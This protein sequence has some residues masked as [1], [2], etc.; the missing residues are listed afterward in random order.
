VLII[1]DSLGVGEANDSAEYGDSGS[2]TLSHVTDDGQLEL[3]ALERFGLYKLLGKEGASQASWSKLSP[4]SQGKSSVEGHWEMMGIVTDNFM[5]TYPDGFPEELL[6]ELSSRIGREIL[7]GKPASGTEII[8]ELGEEHM[9]TGFPIIYTS[10]DSVMQ[11]A[12]H[13]DI[14]PPG[15]LYEICFIARHLMTGKNGVARIIARPFIGKPGYFVRTIR[16]K[17][18]AKQIPTPNNLLEVMNSGQRITCIGRTADFFSNYC[19]ICNKPVNLEE[20][21]NE[22]MMYRKLKGGFLFVNLGDFDSK[23]GHRRDKKGYANELKRLDRV[24]NRLLMSLGNNDLLLVASDHGNDPTFMAHTD[25]TREKTFVMGYMKGYSGQEMKN[26]EIVDI[27]A[28]ICDYFDIKATHGK[29]FL[30]CIKSTRK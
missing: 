27:G 8:S 29:S 24:W 4:K 19:N 12:A 16:R 2:H 5:P 3:Q 7:Y 15:E 11:I 14:I 6:D 9:K 30:G 20:S 21:I 23:Y 25:H 17:D 1:I 28:T 13:E 10:A 26:V 22:A 18:F